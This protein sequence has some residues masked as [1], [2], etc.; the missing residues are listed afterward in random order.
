MAAVDR[1]LQKREEMI[2]LLK[3][4]MA[5][6]QNRMKQLADAR[7]SDRSFEIGDW[8]WLKFQPYRQSTLA[9]RSNEKLSAKYSGP[10]QDEV[11]V[12]K[13]AYKL[14]L[15]ASTK[16]HN[17]FHVSLL[18]P[19]KGTLPSQPHIS[20]WLHGTEVSMAPQP[21]AIL[22]RRTVKR[23]NATHSLV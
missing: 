17:V 11:V 13:V 1:S 14:S 12:G 7:R 15:P 3:H 2:T 22:A 21:L 23:R 18:K 9:T 6:A 10:F 8:V 19:F 5:R 16:V 20:S 4:H